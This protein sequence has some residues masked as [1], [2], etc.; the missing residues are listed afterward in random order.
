MIY[1]GYSGKLSNPELEWAVRLDHLKRIMKH[2]CI[3]SHLLKTHVL[4][5]CLQIATLLFSLFHP[6]LPVPSMAVR[7]LSAQTPSVWCKSL[8]CKSRLR[9]RFVCYIMMMWWE[10]VFPLARGWMIPILLQSLL[11]FSETP[12]SFLAGTGLKAYIMVTLS[13]F[14][15]PGNMNRFDVLSRKKYIVNYGENAGS[16]LAGAI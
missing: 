2:T 16:N 4:R 13:V 15:S 12:C 8:R 3:L 11:L 9:S 5:L 14:W 6:T 7:L 10:D 1:K